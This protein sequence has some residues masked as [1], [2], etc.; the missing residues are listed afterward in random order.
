MPDSLD[1]YVSGGTLRA[2]APSYVERAADVELLETLRQGEF[3]YVLTP[4]Q[5]GKSSLM[6]RVA[7]RLRAVG[8]RVAVLDLTV[9]GSNLTAEQWYFG[10]LTF[11]GDQLDQEEPLLDCWARNAAQG[12]LQRFTTALTELLRADHDTATPPLVLFLD[13]VDAVRS[14]PF[15]TDELFASIRELY[16]RRA[17]DPVLQRLAIC[18]L[19]VATPADL[20]RETRSTPFNIGRRIELNDFTAGEALP[21]ARG[22]GARGPADT[23]IS[24]ALLTRVLYWTSGHPYLTQKLCQ[25]VAETLSAGAP[26]PSRRKAGALVDRVC[27][28]VFLRPGSLLRDDSLLFVQQ[29]M[30]RSG[31]ETPC[32]SADLSARLDRYQKVLSRPER[33]QAAWSSADSGDPVE[34]ALRLSGIVRQDHGGL[35]VRNRIY[36]RLFDSQW[37]RAQMPD[38]ELRRQRRA[39]WRGVTRTA[40]TSGLVISGMG[41]LALD[42]VD[43]EKQ[44]K[45]ALG[46]KALALQQEA[47]A[48]IETRAA[49]AETRRAEERA[50][51]AARRAQASEQREHDAGQRLAREHAIIRGQIARMHVM[52]GMHSAED[53]DAFAALHRFVQALS[54]E[55]GNEERSRAH[56]MR[57]E[58]VLDNA[59]RLVRFWRTTHPGETAD[60]HPDGTRLAVVEGVSVVRILRVENGT[61]ALPALRHPAPVVQVTFSPD[62]SR[63]LTR[64]ED[65][66]I[67]LRSTQT[68]K[69]L[70]PRFRPEPGK[71][72]VCFSPDGK[73]VAACG[74]GGKARVWSAVTGE[75]ISPLLQPKDRIVHLAFSP[76]G[77]LLATAEGRSARIREIVSGKPLID[78]LRHE[79]PVNVVQFLASGNRLVTSDGSSVRT[80]ST[81]TGEAQEVLHREGVIELIPQIGRDRVLVRSQTG[82]LQIWNPSRPPLDSAVARATQPL[83]LVGFNAEGEQAFQVAEDGTVRSWSQDFS[84]ANF[85]PLRLS[86]RLRRAWSSDDQRH[87]L[88]IDHSGEWRLWD[89]APT[90]AMVPTAF[91]HGQ[92]YSLESDSGRVL[93]AEHHGWARRYSIV[94][95]EK[96]GAKFP[97]HRNVSAAAESPD[98]RLVA[99]GHKDGKLQVWDGATGQA[100]SARMQLRETIT[101]LRFHPN[102]RSLLVAYSG[103]RMQYCRIGDWKATSELT[104]SGQITQFSFSPNGRLILGVGDG[105]AQLLTPNA[106]SDRLVELQI[107]ANV[108]SAV[109]SPDSREVLVAKLTGEVSQRSVSD[110]S[111]TG[112]VLNH[113]AT[114][115]YANYSL[116]GR[117]IATACEDGTAQV[118]DRQSGQALTLPL[119][120]GEPVRHLAFS[121]SG[122]RLATLTDS[123]AVRIWAL[124]SGEALTVT[125][126]MGEG[127]GKVAF[128]PD[129][130]TLIATFASGSASTLSLKGCELSLP[131]LSALAERLSGYRYDQIIGAVNLAKSGASPPEATT[132]PTSSKAISRPLAVD[133]GF[134]RAEAHRTR[135]ARQWAS[136]VRHL[137]ALI[138]ALPFDPDLYQARA[139]A[140]AEWGRWPAAARD[141]K[142]ML[143]NAE[144]SPVE[145]HRYALVQLACNDLRGYRT[146]CNEMLRLY[147]TARNERARDLTAWTCA[148]GPQQEPVRARTELVLEELLRPQPENGSL[149]ETLGA[150][151]YRSER[152][153][154]AKQLLRKAA[155]SEG[156]LGTPE[157]YLLL[158]MC[159]ARLG[160]GT[161]A[162]RAFETGVKLLNQD[163][164]SGSAWDTRLQQSL[165][166]REA[167]AVIGR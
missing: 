74:G 6:V 3:C 157:T 27:G 85:S 100:R 5:M 159:E 108:R 68:G 54:I 146:T 139:E 98:G 129:E 117:M 43:K 163:H 83:A 160:N 87:I 52:E 22:L 132:G 137:T 24:R 122:R 107:E 44:M 73:Q 144:A 1:F 47:R 82:H 138:D 101:L 166:L 67:Q 37:I 49:L 154:E 64:T 136:A 10:L 120:H 55:Q 161:E 35:R 71:G 134:H 111:R 76:D 77:R 115:R 92:S 90:R 158:A 126:K 72:T 42:A 28:E 140:F 141:F 99:I 61:P 124:P 88:T 36:A 125:R 143:A 128:S 89:L 51:L 33:N 4:R 59:P 131:S 93:V 63:L 106:T 114:V 38:A 127:P 11:L 26:L 40:V 153:A 75:P 119:R 8:V 130:G 150:L 165:L 80:W 16:N 62:G 15:R 145:W 121:R 32:D 34:A 21:L 135:A 155:A 7:R 167:T 91:P 147:E 46:E 109:F 97:S 133:V 25:R 104:V 86:G 96:Y 94:S 152:F 45:E 18:L 39:F 103:G 151:Y 112:K 79:L 110:W 84:T 78:P 2:D 116:D 123:G 149:L 48:L 162:R 12:P 95:R 164:A 14:L 60:F 29:W 118:W 142:R 56:R 19:G 65:G 102:G 58:S 31:A 50:M 66:W 105:V 30:L 17:L 53:G 57:I 113:Q 23:E 20:I 156:S 148:L 81:Q 9:L 13:E 41:W 70:V 69:L